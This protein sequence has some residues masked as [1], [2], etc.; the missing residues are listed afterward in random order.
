MP[1]WSRPPSAGTSRSASRT[2]GCPGPGC[3]SS[4]PRPSPRSAS[5]R[6]LSTPPPRRCRV[7]RPSGS[8]SRGPWRWTPPSSCST[9]RRR[10][11]TPAA[12]RRCGAPS[13][14]WPATA[15]G[16]SWS[17]STC[18]VR[19]STSSS[20]SSC[21]PPRVRWWRT[22]RFGRCWRPSGSA[23]SPWA[24]GCRAPRR[25]T[26]CPSPR[27]WSVAPG[28]RS[29]PCVP[30]RS[31]SRGAR[32]CSTARPAVPARPS[33]PRP[34]RPPREASPR[35]SAPAGRGSRRSSRHSPASSR[36]RPGA[37]WW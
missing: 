19:G 6:C 29:R 20:G 26:R 23:W 31:P 13:P 37:P 5:G 10:C 7:G 24:S 9:N 17:S 16:R 11:S 15:G 35:S 21:C 3:P 28:A 33:S 14:R 36:P 4:S 1:G 32:G 18:S 2:S 12:P 34:S 25:R 30:S 8:R 27:G 22:V